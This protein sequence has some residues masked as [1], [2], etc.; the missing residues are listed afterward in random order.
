MFN[1]MR[2][3][4]LKLSI[5]FLAVSLAGVG[6][7]AV[8]IWGTTSREFNQF[9]FDRG[10]SEFAAAA[11]TYYE[12]NNS[13]N[14]I[15]DGLTQQRLLPPDKPQDGHV[16]HPPQPFALVD[17][18]GIVMVGGG[19]FNL[20]DTVPADVINKGVAITVNGQHVGTVISTGNQ[21]GRDSISARFLGRINDALMVAALGASALALLL[22]IF[23]AR[24][25]T[26]P[27]RDLTAASHAMA[28]GQ[29]KQQVEVR[30][31]DELGELTATFNQMSADLEHSNQLRRQMTADIAHDL[32]TPLGVITGYLES[33]RDGVLKPTPERYDAIYS[34]AKH[35]QRL[36][37]DLRT[38]SLA[39]AGELKINRQPVQPAD[40][41]ERL[42]Q[43]FQHQAGQLQVSLKLVVDPS[44][45]DIFV[46]PERIEQ[47]LG[48]LVSNSLR[49]TPEGGEIE[50]SAHAEE[51]GVRLAVRDNGSGMAPDVIIHIFERFYR[52]D[53]SRA[54]Q[55]EESGLG[56][57]IAKSVVEL[58]GGKINASS[59]GIGH[60]TTI[61]ILL[62]AI[63]S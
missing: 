23:L 20:G 5:A 9:L 48:N 63:S 29:L 62:P 47:V 56:L 57:A 2:S 30:S 33:M 32:R 50:F 49:Y 8:F 7:V 51:G 34:E 44:L 19:P 58:H 45:P 60:G 15:V 18:N 54:Q 31:R 12:T 52:G 14:G 6:L 35:L 25:L 22:G 41:L 21:P 36:V 4:S 16:P 11:T 61:S 39:D 17:Q 40:L 53:D 38:L 46:D 42:V 43:A 10:Q 27:L 24:T 1:K 13:W 3:L 28:S 59:Q 37:E 26:R 55:G